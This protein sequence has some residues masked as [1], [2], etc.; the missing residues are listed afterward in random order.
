MLGLSGSPRKRS[1]SLLPVKI[2][3]N[4][5]FAFLNNFGEKKFFSSSEKISLLWDL[6]FFFLNFSKNVQNDEKMVWETIF[7]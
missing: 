1:L 4:F 6:G 5:F 7:S 3:G 2:A